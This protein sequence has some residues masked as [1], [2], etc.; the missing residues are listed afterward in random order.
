MAKTKIIC[1]LGPASS[2]YGTLKKM[3][4]AGMSIARLNF[5]HGTHEEHRRLIDT[6]RELNRKENSEI[7]ILQDLE[8]FRIRVGEFDGK[9]KIEL[10][11]D[12][13]LILTSKLDHHQGKTIP[14]DYEGPLDEIEKGN[15]VFIDDGYIALEVEDAHKDYLQARVITPGTVKQHKGIN[16][17]GMK[18]RA[19]A[20]TDKD[21]NDLEFG[22][23]QKVDLI[24]QS[25]VRNRDD[26]SPIVERL[27]KSGSNIPV[28]AKIENHEGIENIG[29]ILDAVDGIMVARGDLGVSFPIYEVPV[30]QKE[31]IGKCREKNKMVV[32]ATQMLE[33]MTKSSRPTRAEVSDVANAILD[34]SSHVMLSGE[35]AVGDYPVETVAMMS[36]IISYTERAVAERRIGNCGESEG[37]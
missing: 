33:T 23:S 21:K 25:F 30:M 5:S 18:F 4:E 26:I 37:K 12:E 8:G 13:I 1:T 34:G 15:R 3:A 2:D 10:E 16:I 29:G 19:S 24:A 20:I 36:S 9:D 14:F 32:T 31:I 35:T 17:P 27:K 11:K 28:I 22:L 7:K 6:I